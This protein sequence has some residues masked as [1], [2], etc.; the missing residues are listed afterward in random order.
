MGYARKKVSENPRATSKKQRDSHEV[1][2]YLCHIQYPFLFQEN[3]ISK[4]PYLDILSEW[5][6]LQ[7]Q[8]DSINLV[9]V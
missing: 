8:E 3:T 2:M 9:S 6:M 7:L 5:L 1:H 4:A